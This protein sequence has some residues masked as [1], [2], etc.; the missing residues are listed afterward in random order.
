M[1]CVQ[2]KYYQKQQ[3]RRNMLT[4]EVEVEM[5][6]SSNNNEKNKTMLYADVINSDVNP[7]IDSIADSE[8]L[9]HK[10][11]RCNK[12]FAMPEYQAR[13]V[14]EDHIDK[15]YTCLRG[16][17][18]ISH[19]T[20]HLNS[21]KIDI[22]C[23]MRDKQFTRSDHLAKHLK[24]HLQ[25]DKCYICNECGKAFN[26]F[27][28]L[29]TH[30][31]IH[32]RKKRSSKLHHC[33]H[34]GKEFMRPYNMVVLIR[35]HTGVR[36]YKCSQCGKGFS[37]LDSLKCHER[38][39]SGEKPH[40]CRKTFETN[41]TLRKH[42]RVHTGERPYAYNK[43]D[44]AYTETNDLARHMRRHTGARPYACGMY[45]ARFIES[46][47]LKAQ[48]IGRK[49]NRTSNAIVKTL[50]EKV[51]EEEIEVHETKVSLPNLNSIGAVMEPTVMEDTKLFPLYSLNEVVTFNAVE[52]NVD[53]LNVRIKSEVESN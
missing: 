16:E 7:N 4:H 45:P 48:D 17:Q 51:L 40:M 22:K 32:T 36:P 41:S 39:H 26:R 1:W 8:F 47:Q 14:Q 13:H 28:N 44:K 20:A 19:L 33:V 43:C 24:L 49:R 11:H 27:D 42:T 10:C 15:P 9:I 12:A 3:L 21:T 53:E 18:L 23:S 37:S 29:K 30:Q 25:Q 50:N 52:E 38:S 46:M 6:K 2:E 35:R 31:K 34:C 5:K